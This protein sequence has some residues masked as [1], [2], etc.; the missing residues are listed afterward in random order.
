LW[1]EP[2]RAILVPVAVPPAPLA[3]DYA[4]TPY[5]WDD[6]AARDPQIAH[7]P[8]RADVVVVGG[9]LTGLAAAL[10]LARSGCGVVV[11]ERH[12]VGRG[13]S[14]R[15]GGMAHPG[16][17]HDLAT[18]LSVPGGRAMWQDSVA[19]FEGLETLIADLGVDCDWHRSGH[20]EL[21]CHR[22]SAS[23]LRAVAA[24]HDSIGERVEYLGPGDLR[25]E[26]GSSS[27]RG[28]MV[29]HRSAAVHPAR[30]TAG[31]AAAAEAAGAATFDGTE[32][33]GIERAAGGHVVRTTRGPVRA[34]DVVVATDGT[35]DRRLVPWLGRRV[36]GVGSF[37]IATEPLDPSVVASVSPNGRMLFDTRNFLHYWRPSPDGRRVLFGGRT[38]FAPTTLE[39]ARDQLH[40]AMVAVHPQ[41]AG[42]GV[43]RAWGGQVGL[44]ADRLPHIGRHLESGVV[45]AMGYGGT[46]VALSTHF[47]RSIGRWLAG[48]GELPS[49]AG[50]RWPAVPAPAWVPALLGVAGWWYRARDALGR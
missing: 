46:G 48:T 18:L 4:P 2:E 33:L 10:E 29:V 25:G 41:L 3:A 22:R 45:Y 19:A 5:W 40:A 15:N 31:L 6:V 14:G 30:L 32:A 47:G 11:L 20:V 35:T 44:T 1:S 8:A 38:S 7:P 49:F 17:K 24:A 37:M 42:A 9:G 23:H 39:R 36:L 16:A 26:V 28:G 21:A 13:A 12:V 27:F 43:A 50:G 34:G